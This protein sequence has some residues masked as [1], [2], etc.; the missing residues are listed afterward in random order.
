MILFHGFLPP[1]M[2]WIISWIILQ[3][4]WYAGLFVAVDWLLYAAMCCGQNPRTVP[5][6]L[7]KLSKCCEIYHASRRLSF[8]NSCIKAWCI[9]VLFCILI[10]PPKWQFIWSIYTNWHARKL[11]LNKGVF[12]VYSFP[13]VK[14]TGSA[15]WGHCDWLTVNYSYFDGSVLRL[16][17]DP[18]FVLA[19]RI[20]TYNHFCQILGIQLTELC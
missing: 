1:F 7:I 17:F 18:W 19:P 5:Y 2:T 16:W 20:R 6:H 12:F 14:L 10:L 13:C 8:F 11:V 9:H 4:L 3:L 15:G